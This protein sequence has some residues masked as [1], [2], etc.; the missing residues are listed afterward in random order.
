MRL[1]FPKNIP[2]AVNFNY[3]SHRKPIFSGFT[4]LSRF[5]N[6]FRVLSWV[7]IISLLLLVTTTT[8]AQTFVSKSVKAAS[9]ATT[10]RSWRMEDEKWKFLQIYHLQ[11]FYGIIINYHRHKVQ[12]FRFRPMDKC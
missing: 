11:Y 6:C 1:L 7:L 10:V 8:D 3:F 2:V 9:K 4:M 12:L 5:K